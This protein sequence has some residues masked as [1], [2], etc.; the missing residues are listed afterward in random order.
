[1]EIMFLM[2][3]VM[4][5]AIMIVLFIW[6]GM[7]FV[8]FIRPRKTAES[9]DIFGTTIVI[10]AYN[11]EKNIGDCLESIKQSDFPKSKLEVIVVDDG[12]SDRTVEIAEKF[13]A[14]IIKQ[15]HEGKV[16]ALNEGIKNS[17]Y[18]LV[19]TMD[20]D[21]ILEPG[22][23]S[24]I[25]KPMIDENVGA[26]SGVS[27]VINKNGILG[28]FQNVEYIYLEFIRETVSNL[29]RT[30]PGIRGAFSCFRKEAINKAGGFDDRTSAED[31]DIA[32]HMKKAG[33]K[34]LLAPKAISHTIVPDTL[35]GLFNQ[36]FRWSKGILQSIFLHR[37][38]FGR[39]GSA[40]YVLGV[41][42]F[43]YVIALFSIPLIAYNVLY[44][45][46]FNMATP[47]DVFSYFFRWFSFAGIV[48]MIYMIP[49]WGINIV[50]IFGIISGIITIIL[51]GIAHNRYNEKITLRVIIG[52]FFYFP[53]TILLNL[54]LIGGILYFAIKKGKG[55][56]S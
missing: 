1:M 22:A 44:W 55:N 33:Y 7:V 19:V 40:S 10:P 31:F 12:S 24:E 41:H 38:M 29:L 5:F 39:S 49:E 4:F 47:L 48:H 43:W 9:G 18:D 20:A 14:K 34:I 37:D 53:Y 26:V 30:S 21:T 42:F 56:F 16:A 23:L 50:Y 27:K 32:F 17:M 3:T 11:E 45:L 35:K 51:M 36:R 46:P 13:G 2:T 54:T 6:V 28:L 52:M 25:V 8:F 15:G